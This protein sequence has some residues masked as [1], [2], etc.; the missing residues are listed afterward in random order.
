MPELTFP[1]Q[2]AVWPPT[3]YQATG[4]APYKVA[5]VGSM[6][7]SFLDICNRFG[8]KFDDLILFNFGLKRSEPHFFEK[9]NWFLK[10]KLSC[11]KTT[12]DGNFIFS[13]GETLYIPPRG[14]SFDDVKV[15][16]PKPSGDGTIIETRNY[17]PAVE[18]RTKIQRCL[19]LLQ[20]KAP[21]Y[22]VW[23]KKY[24]LRIRDDPRRSGANFADGSAIDI[25][26]ETF[27][28]SD[29]W[30]ASVIIHESI[31][32]WQYRDGHYKTGADQYLSEQEANRYQTGVLQ[33]IGAPQNELDWMA[34]QDGRHADLNH[35]GV[36]DEK[37]EKLRRY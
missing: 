10:N 21:Q 28:R 20:N 31:H 23:F 33:L 37:D 27:I 7:E 5:R 4:V 35:D 13:G 22:F 2:N 18:F 32:F 3:N 16:V 9:I 8:I 1:P 19:D 17:I 30:V 36:Y 6:G 25:A 14:Y 29:T 26:N 12:H 24:N 34:K 11:T 15:V